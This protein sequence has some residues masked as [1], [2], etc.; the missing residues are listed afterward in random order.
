MLGRSY[1]LKPIYWLDGVCKY[2]E[3]PAHMWNFMYIDTCSSLFYKGKQ[4]L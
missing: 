4:L 1:I 3:Q 2:L